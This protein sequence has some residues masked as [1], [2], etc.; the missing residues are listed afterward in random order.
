[1]KGNTLTSLAIR[2]I[3]PLVFL[4]VDGNAG[5]VAVRGDAG[6][7]R[8]GEAEE[9]AVGDGLHCFDVEEVVGL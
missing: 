9:G 4:A 6:E 5:D 1:M 3:R 8:R 7:E 2:H